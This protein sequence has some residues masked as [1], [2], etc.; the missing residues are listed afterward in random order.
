VTLPQA[1]IRVWTCILIGGAIFAFALVA[2]VL[3]LSKCL[4]FGLPND[5][6]FHTPGRILHDLINQTLATLPNLSYIWKFI[7]VVDPR[8]FYLLLMS[9]MLWS[10]VGWKIV[11]YAN[12][13]KGRIRR[14]N[15]A[16]KEERRKQSLGQAPSNVGVL[17]IQIG[18]EDQWHA[19]P[20]GQLL[21]GLA[22][23]VGGGLLL[24][25]VDPLS[26]PSRS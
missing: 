10:A 4:Y 5:P 12:S 18:S 14:V 22:I 1:K 20:S 16:I 17:S 26:F 25:L 8:F 15:Q 23:E 2:P 21:I 19:K 7:P 11:K 6:I 9:A 24:L 13:L 3:V